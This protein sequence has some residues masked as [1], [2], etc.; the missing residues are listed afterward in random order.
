MRT[1]CNESNYGG[2]VYIE[3]ILWTDKIVSKERNW[4]E[5]LNKNFHAKF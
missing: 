2:K 1:L 5:K 3:G 4:R